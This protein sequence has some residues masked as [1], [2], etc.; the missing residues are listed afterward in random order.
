M[1]W[2]RGWLFVSLAIVGTF[3][4][5]GG[6]TDPSSDA[7]GERQ[8][9]QIVAD[10]AAAMAE[11]ESAAFTIEQSGGTIFIDDANQLEFQSAVGRYA[12]PSA[13]EALID[14]S[15][16]GFTTEVG[17]VTI[18]GTLWFTNPLSGAWTEAPASFTFDLATLFAD[19]VGFPALLTEATATAELIDD[20][21]GQDDVEVDVDQG[22]PHHI[23]T[24]VTAERVAVLTGG[25]VTEKTDVDLWIDAATNRIVEARFDLPVGDDISSWRMTISDYDEDVT[26]VPPELGTG[27]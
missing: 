13:A 1:V 8:V 22:E 27:G 18:D 26:I 24:A 10:A 12:R 4:A 2:S 20:A 6:S 14:V 3:A 11:I 19:D 7:S 21:A 25:L 15:A 16:F 17:A 5:C 23:R 9:D